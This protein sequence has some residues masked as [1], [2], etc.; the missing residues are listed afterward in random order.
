MSTQ[1]LVSAQITA[2]VKAQIQT[3]INAIAALLPF[4][5]SLTAAERKGG[6]KLGDKTV[7]FIDKAIAYAQAN[8][9]FVPPYVN[10]T[11]IQKDYTLQKDLNDIQQWMITLIQKIED[12]HQEAGIEALNGILGFYQAVSV[13]TDKDVPG[14]RSIYEDLNVRFPGRKKTKTPPTPPP[15]AK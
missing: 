14:A 12:T 5:I 3:N 8:P 6:I 9:A 10:L 1:N 13:A 2:A 11:E 7:A 4:L 15:A